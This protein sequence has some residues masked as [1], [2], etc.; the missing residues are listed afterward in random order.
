MNEQCT[1]NEGSTR[2]QPLGADVVAEM[3][4]DDE[5]QA[6]IMSTAS[7]SNS[8]SSIGSTTNVEGENDKAAAGR[9]GGDDEVD[10]VVCPLFMDGLPRDFVSNPQLAAIASL[11]DSSG[12]EE[13]NDSDNNNDCASDAT[14]HHDVHND[15]DN[16]T[17][18]TTNRRV[19]KFADDS[20]MD[21]SSSTCGRIPMVVGGNVG[22]RNR[23]SSRRNR[24]KAN[25]AATPYPTRRQSRN[26]VN[27]KNNK[28]KKTSIGEAQLFLNMWK[29]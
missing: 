12:D 16:D 11:L 17:I 6:V 19:D 3:E 15:D 24:L 26:D 23:L 14:D 1:N 20:M 22:R 29:L 27:K 10:D 13:N 5:E 21:T 7:S 8:S 25:N 18:V 2:Q 9:T 4:T 28:E